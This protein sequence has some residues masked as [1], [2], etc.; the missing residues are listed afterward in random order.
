MNNCPFCNTKNAYVGFTEVE[1]PNLMCKYF[2]EK[3][4]VAATEETQKTQRAIF[5]GDSSLEEPYDD[6]YDMLADLYKYSD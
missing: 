2:S 1:C 6:Y 3:Q 4:L 5:T